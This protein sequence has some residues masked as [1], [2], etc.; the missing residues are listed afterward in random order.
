MTVSKEKRDG[1]KVKVKWY[2]TKNIKIQKNKT[3]YQKHKV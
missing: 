3:N 2:A 1:A